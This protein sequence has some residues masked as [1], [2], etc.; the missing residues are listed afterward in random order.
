MD[1]DSRFP[2]PKFH[3][4]SCQQFFIADPMNFHFIF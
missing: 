1:V 2:L 4:A 3:K